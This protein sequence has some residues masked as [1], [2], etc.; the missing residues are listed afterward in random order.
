M[1]PW[2]LAAMGAF[3]AVVHPAAAIDPREHSD[4]STKQFSVF[5]E[6][7]PLR[8]RVVS[9]AEEVKKE[10]LRLLDEGGLWKAPIVIAL[11]PASV[12]RPDEPAARVRLIE[13]LPGFKVAIDVKI[14]KDPAAVNLQRHIVRAL[15]LEYAYREIGVQGGMAFR[16]APWWL[17]D[18]TIELM[19]QRESG[20]DVDLFR[21]LSATNK[22]PPVGSFLNERPEEVAG[23]ALAVDQALA[24]C[25]LQLLTSQPHGKAALARVLRAWPRSGGNSFALLKREF[26]KLITD[27]S[28]LQKWWMLSLARCAAADRHR[29]LTVE[30]TEKE[31]TALVVIEVPTGKPG[32]KQTFAVGDFAKYLKLPASRA[33]LAERHTLIVALS[34]RANALYRPVLAEYEQ[35]FALLA[36]GKTRGVSE[37]LA[38]IEQYRVSVR[39]RTVEIADYL[40]WFEGTQMK[41]SSNAFDDYL[42]TANE[43]S[44][45]EKKTGPISRYLDAMELEY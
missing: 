10:V 13:S 8:M 18:G 32:E 2:A 43:I 34:T 38:R 7:V 41:E 37:R 40:N 14:G 16:E 45:Q 22:L 11:E 27:E 35:A 28:T 1:K 26:P 24:G 36:R 21:R 6:D 9:F 23:N 12:E 17:V 39:R 15:Y 42:R 19:R 33:V 30:E 31:L 29:G 25:L 5:C 44:E 3:L 4:S 20:V